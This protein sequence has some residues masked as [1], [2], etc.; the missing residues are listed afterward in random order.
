TVAHD[1]P[2]AVRTRQQRK[3]PRRIGSDRADDLSLFTAHDV[4]RPV[5][6]ATGEP[7][8]DRERTAR[9]S[10]EAARK[11]IQ[12]CGALDIGHFEPTLPAADHSARDARHRFVQ[13]VTEERCESLR[14]V[15]AYML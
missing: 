10:H 7:G 15:A 13:P 1:R 4:G 6:V 3:R 11:R 9:C 14:K 5:V 8:N 2:L 12:W